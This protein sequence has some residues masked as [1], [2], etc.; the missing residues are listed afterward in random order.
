M[1]AIVIIAAVFANWIAPYSPNQ[2]D[3]LHMLQYPSRLH[4]LGTDELG[5]DELSR[6]LFGART[7]LLVTVG[8]TFIGTAIGV[9]VGLISGYYG[10]VLDNLLIMRI[11]DAMQAFPFLILALVLAAMLGPGL[12]NAMIA[13]GIGYVPIMVRIVRGQ[14]LAERSKEYIVSSRVIG[15]KDRRILFIHLLPNVLSPLFIQISLAMASGIVAEASLSYLGLGTQPP[16][17]SWGNMLKTGQGYLITDPLLSVML[18]LAI[19]FAV[20]A[21]NLLGDGLR[22]LLDPRINS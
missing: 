1:V 16:A 20:L 18:G 11:V 14:V 15:S 6:I 10:G 17:A 9:P 3:Y 4:W 22:D 7:S 5:R 13:I 8:A 19:V 21:F 2:P 12:G